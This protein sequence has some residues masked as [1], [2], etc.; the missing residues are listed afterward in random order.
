VNVNPAATKLPKTE[1]AQPLGQADIMALTWGPIQE[2]FAGRS[3]ALTAATSPKAPLRKKL[4]IASIVISS[5]KSKK[6]K[7]TNSFSSPHMNN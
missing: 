4:L 3:P 2:D 6:N 7:A 1:S 5:N